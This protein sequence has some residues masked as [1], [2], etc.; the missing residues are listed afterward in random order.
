M[1]LDIFITDRTYST[2]SKVIRAIFRFLRVFLVSRKVTQ[3]KNLKKYISHY[4]V[5]TPVEKCMEILMEARNSIEDQLML[6]DIEWCMQMLSSNKLYDPLMAFK[7]YEDDG[8]P[9]EQNK[10]VHK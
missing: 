9:T 6:K 5:K 2:V 1:V 3:F 4:E 8:S 10:E 7:K